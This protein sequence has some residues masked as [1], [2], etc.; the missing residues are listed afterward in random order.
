MHLCFCVTFFCGERKIDIGIVIELKQKNCE[1][2]VVQVYTCE[3]TGKNY[4]SRSGLASH[5]KT[6]IHLQ[7]EQKS[8]IRT[9]RMSITQKDN[10]IISLKSDKSLL[11][12]L[13][14][15]LARKLKSRA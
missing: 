7:W 14:L 15:M 12:E 8:E 11:Q 10:E 2:E 4:K 9:L 1:M 3:C 13:N 6:K 5:Q